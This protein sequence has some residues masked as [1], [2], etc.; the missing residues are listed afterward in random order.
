M[1]ADAQK[2]AVDALQHECIRAFT[3]VTDYE[4]WQDIH[5]LYF[6]CD[7]DKAIPAAIQEQMA[8]ILGPD[9]IIFRSKA[10]HSPFLSAVQDV[11]DGIEKAAAS[12]QEDVSA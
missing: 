5:C 8:G 2:K 4:P 12:G 9:S 3:D 11:V 1:S 10:S 7:E 6:V